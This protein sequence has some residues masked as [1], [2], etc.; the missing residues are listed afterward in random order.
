MAFFG[1]DQAE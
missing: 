1:H